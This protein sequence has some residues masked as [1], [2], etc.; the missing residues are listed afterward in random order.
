MH[1]VRKSLDTCLWADEVPDVANDGEDDVPDLEERDEDDEDEEDSDDE[2][3]EERDAMG[4]D[5]QSTA[6]AEAGI[7]YEEDEED[8]D[9]LPAEWV[10]GITSFMEMFIDAEDGFNKESRLACLWTT[11]HLWPRGCRYAFNCYRHQ[12]K[13]YVRNCGEEPIILLSKE[14]VAQGDP[15]SMLLYGLGTVP[16][17]K[18]LKSERELASATCTRGEQWS[19]VMPWYADDF[20]STGTAYQQAVTMKTLLKYG[21]GFGINPRPEK[22]WIICDAKDEAATKEIF[23]REGLDIQFTRG[24]RYLGG[25]IGTDASKGEWMAEKVEQWVHSIEVLE[26]IGRRYPQSAYYGMSVS[27]QNEWQHVCRIVPDA[28]DYLGPVEVA[29][30]SFLSTL[31]DVGLDEQ[32]TLRELLGHRVKNAGIGIGDPTKY[33]AE[34]FEVSEECVSY[35]SRSLKYGNEIDVD[36][37]AKVARNGRNMCSAARDSAEKG[38]V[39]TWMTDGGKIEEH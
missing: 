17:A 26:N 6:E 5:S 38:R 39:N 13:C 14:G 30:K 15:M 25:F 9:D 22:S 37:H 34:C 28:G 23:T 20:A 1:A 3:E 4:D 18:L 12:A 8:M 2:E 11:R 32:G 7:N 27:L 31:L 35:L 24:M 16:L 10:A 21:P 36:Q 19:P 29:L 33:A